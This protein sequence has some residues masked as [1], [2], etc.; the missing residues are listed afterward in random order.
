MQLQGK[1]EEKCPEIRLPKEKLKMIVDK[2]FD[3]KDT[4]Q[5]FITSNTDKQY[6][7]KIVIKVSE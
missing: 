4:H 3:L 6:I 7:T 5:A 2:V 1:E